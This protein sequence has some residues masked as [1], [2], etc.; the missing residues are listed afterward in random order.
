MRVFNAVYASGFALHCLLWP[1]PAQA[2]AP[3]DRTPDV[4]AGATVATHRV[5]LRP[6]LREMGIVPRRQG[7][8]P[9]CSVFT[10]AAGLEFALAKRVGHAPR[11][12]V[13]FLNWAACQACGRV[14]DG[15]FFSDLWQGF[16]TAGICAEEA[17][18]YQPQFDPGLR[19]TPEALAEAKARKPLGL[20]LNW[21]KRWDVKTGLAPSEFDGIQHSLEEGWPVCGGFRWPTHAR[22]VEGVLQMCAAHEVFDGH[23]VLIVGFRDDAA[24]P[25]GGVFV[26]RNTTGDGRDGLMPYAYARLYMNDAASITAEVP[27]TAASKSAPAASVPV[28]E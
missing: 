4:L 18:P 1:G 22:W 13:E 9:T 26:F 14:K 7:S 16:E 27:P 12:S 25:G 11:M 15:G 23:S 10:V 2:Q 5:D 28:L 20:R 17:M 21:I 6:V 19:P 8:R 3:A 24:Q